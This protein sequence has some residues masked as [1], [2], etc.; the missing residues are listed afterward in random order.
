MF[1]VYIIRSLQ[2]DWWYVGMTSD[3]ERLDWRFSQS[4]SPA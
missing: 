3:F 1:V 2:K 4:I